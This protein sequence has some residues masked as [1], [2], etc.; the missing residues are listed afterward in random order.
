[1]VRQAVLGY[2]GEHPERHAEQSSQDEGGQRELEGVAEALHQQTP[3]RQSL[4]QRGAEVALH[5]AA[6]P[7]RVAH[8]DRFVEPVL[9]VKC[10]ALGSSAL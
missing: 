10:L 5:D 1:M 7:R 8:H 4:S 6:E 9:P 2:G 3:D